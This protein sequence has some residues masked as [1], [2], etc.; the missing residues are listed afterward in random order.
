MIVQ[1]GFALISTTDAVKLCFTSGALGGTGTRGRSECFAGAW[2]SRW[3]GYE[4]VEHKAV[5]L[6]AFHGARGQGLYT[7]AVRIAG[8]WIAVVLLVRAAR[9]SSPSP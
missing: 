9:A 8:L 4:E 7:Y 3:H 2:L 5:L 1:C 6:D